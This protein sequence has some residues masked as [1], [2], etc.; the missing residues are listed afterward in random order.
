MKTTTSI[1]GDRRL[2]GERTAIVTAVP[3]GRPA[4]AG[5]SA[6]D[7]VVLRQG[8]STLL[9]ATTTPQT[10]S[11]TRTLKT[12]ASPPPSTIPSG[13]LQ[14]ELIDQHAITGAV[15]IERVGA[16]DAEQLTIAGRDH[17]GAPITVGRQ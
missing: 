1:A 4:F 5:R 12:A 2:I 11:A 17:P 3:S 7:A 15:G 16:I 14:R 10:S 6:Q 8:R 9:S 13:W